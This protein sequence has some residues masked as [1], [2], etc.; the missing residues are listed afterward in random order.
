VLFTPE[1]DAAILRGG[2]DD[3]TLADMLFMS[4]TTLRDRRRELNRPSPNLPKLPK[5]RHH[6]KRKRWTDEQDERL[7]Q[8]RAD[9]LLLLQVA[10]T[11]GR[12]VNSVRTRW[13]RL[14]CGKK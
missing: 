8:F 3:R 9:G 2:W 4:V 7:R 6:K 1:D 10:K 5:Y 11:M 12:S 14:E 13:C